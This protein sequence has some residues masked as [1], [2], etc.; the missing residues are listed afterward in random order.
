M[1]LMC[2]KCAVCIHG[3]IGN[4]YVMEVIPILGRLLIRFPRILLIASTRHCRIQD[5]AFAPFSKVNIPIMAR[6]DDYTQHLSKHL[7]N[8]NSFN[9][10][11]LQIENV[12]TE[13]WW[14]FLGAEHLKR[15]YISVRNN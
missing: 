5:K 12:T 8:F 4:A 14:I 2:H 3:Y 11:S 10:L 9:M 1:V 13:K 7:P 6:I 15:V